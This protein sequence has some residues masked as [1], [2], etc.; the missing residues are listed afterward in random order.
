VR[1]CDAVFGGAMYVSVAQ[2][3]F[4]WVN[5]DTNKVQ[6]L[7]NFGSKDDKKTKT[8]FQLVKNDRKEK[9]KSTYKPKPYKRRE[10]TKENDAKN[11]SYSKWN[12]THPSIAI[13][14]IEKHK[15][16]FLQ[17]YKGGSFNFAADYALL[18]A[19]LSDLLM[20]DTFKSLH[21]RTLTSWYKEAKMHGSPSIA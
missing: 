11:P 9:W 7:F 16:A 8:F 21:I 2:T 12:E 17:K 19:A 5:K 20:L 10:S 6:T 3:Q 14:Y 13:Q 1:L 18:R 15:K 4:M